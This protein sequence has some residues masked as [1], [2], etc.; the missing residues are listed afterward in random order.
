[1]NAAELLLEHL[2]KDIVQYVVMDYIMPDIETVKKQ[3]KQ[4]CD[5]VSKCSRTCRVGGKRH[6]KIISNFRQISRYRFIQLWTDQPISY[7]IYCDTEYIELDTGC[8]CYKSWPNIRSECLCDNQ[9]YYLHNKRCEF[10][11][12]IQ[13]QE[14]SCCCIQ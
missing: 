14:E 1:M 5:I 12:S 10:L 2:P 13:P 4:I 11:L 7:C 8:R 3:K 6:S 9:Q